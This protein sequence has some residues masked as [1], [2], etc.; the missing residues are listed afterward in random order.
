MV[1]TARCLWKQSSKTMAPQQK[2]YR[3]VCYTFYHVD[4]NKD[5]PSTWKTEGWE[6]DHPIE[7]KGEGIV[8]YYVWQ[9]EKTQT[10]RIHIQGFC[11]LVRRLRLNQIKEMF[12]NKT[13]HIEERYSN[14]TD[15]AAAKYC[16]KKE[17]RLCAD[18]E[19]I[20]WGSLENV[21]RGKRSDIRLCFESIKTG[22]PMQ[23]I[24]E[25]Y[26]EVSF[27]YSRMVEKLVSEQVRKRTRDEFRDMEVIVY[28]GGS[29]SGKTQRVYKEVKEKYGT[30][31]AMHKLPQ[32]HPCWFNGYTHQPVLFIDDFGIDWTEGMNPCMPR[33]LLLHIMD[34]Y[35][36]MLNVKH[37]EFAEA[38][39]TTVYI[40]ANEPPVEWFHA[41]TPVRKQLNQQAIER[42]I[43]KLEMMVCQ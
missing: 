2:Q 39:F 10:G 17:T 23:E 43:T 41:S 20:E 4:E 38:L 36:L 11:R 37:G 14:G 6:F 15:E 3:S 16:T 40:T 28:W 5:D 7:Y 35:P 29:G 27:K 34:R 32:S 33:A 19:P 31:A 25:E 24:L 21:G 22:M 26:T 18:V 1:V 13:M 12:Q 9:F 42:R 30:H 8:A